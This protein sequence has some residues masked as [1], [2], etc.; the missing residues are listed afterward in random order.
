MSVASTNATFT[1]PVQHSHRIDGVVPGDPSERPTSAMQI[2]RLVGLLPSQTTSSHRNI[3]P[4]QNRADGT[5]IYA[6]PVSQLICRRTGHVALDQSL[7]RH[8]DDAPDAVQTCRPAPAVDP[9]RQY[10]LDRYPPGR[11]P[12]AVPG[13][14]VPSRS[15]RHQAGHDGR[16]IHGSRPIE[17][18][19]C[20]K[21]PYDHPRPGPQHQPCRP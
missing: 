5:T 8:R 11:L 3:A 2:N 9:Y 19:R 13:Q 10:P 16:H 12:A 7:P 18:R 20:S 21:L 15:S 4:M 17:D 1:Q 6:K 14:Q